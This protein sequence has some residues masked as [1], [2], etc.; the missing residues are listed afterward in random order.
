MYE[1]YDF[2]SCLAKS[3]VYFVYMVIVISIHQMADKSVQW[4]QAAQTTLFEAIWLQL[5]GQEV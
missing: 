4:K 5:I 1:N 3:K 2:K